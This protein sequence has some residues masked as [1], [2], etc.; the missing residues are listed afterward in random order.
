MEHVIHSCI[1]SHFE[2][3][4]ILTDCQH[5]LKKRRSCKDTTDHDTWR[6]SKR[7]KWVT[8]SWRRP[9]WHFKDI[10]QGTPPAV[11]SYAWTLWSSWKPLE[12]DGRLSLSKNSRGGHRWHQVTAFAISSGVPQVTVLLFLAY[13]NDMLEA[14]WSTVK[15]FADNSLVYRKISNKRD[16]EGL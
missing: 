1:I 13:I 16:C 2:R 15:L 8:A 14:I 10:R 4:N 3:H 5:G 9:P 12:V 7:T 11:T 6:P